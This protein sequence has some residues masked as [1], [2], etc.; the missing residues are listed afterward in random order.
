VAENVSSLSWDGRALQN[1]IVEASTDSWTCVAEPGVGNRVVD[2]DVLSRLISRHEVIVAVEYHLAPRRSPLP[3]ATAR[4]A[5]AY[6]AS[7]IAPAPRIRAGTADRSGEADLPDDGDLDEPLDWEDESDNQ[8]EQ[9]DVF[10]NPEFNHDC[11]LLRFLQERLSGI[12]L[13]IPYDTPARHQK[14]SSAF[15]TLSKHIEKHLA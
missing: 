14:F 4:E 8:W 15:V 6:I 3:F 5:M 11:R 2:V 7:C 9:D 10:T 1:A 13:I 12:D